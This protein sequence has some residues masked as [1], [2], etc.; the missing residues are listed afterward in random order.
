MKYCTHCKIEKP[1]DEFSWKNKRLGIR[2]LECKTC[3]R[4]MRNRHYANNSSAE[5]SRVRK[6]KRSLSDWLFSI[7]QDRKCMRC[8]FDHPA[9][10]DFHHRDASKKVFNVS[11]APLYGWSKENILK[12][13]EKCDVLCSNCHRV[14]HFDELLAGVAQRQSA[15]LPS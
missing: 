10:L 11:Q 7:K 12:E 3:H 4:E 2:S 6:R 15:I 14:L 9:A 5:I 8:G 13:I 1:L